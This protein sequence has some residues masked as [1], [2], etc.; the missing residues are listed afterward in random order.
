MQLGQGHPANKVEDSGL[1][2]GLFELVQNTKAHGGAGKLLHLTHVRVFSLW[3][4]TFV[5]LCILQYEGQRKIAVIANLKGVPLGY[6]VTDA[7]SV[8]LG[9][10]TVFCR[11][12]SIKLLELTQFNLYQEGY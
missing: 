2:S 10:A 11:G 12:S 5:V 1:N 7:G 3:Q 9:V 4:R 8:L 6:F